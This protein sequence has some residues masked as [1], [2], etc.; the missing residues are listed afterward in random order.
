MTADV[1][2]DITVTTG[3]SHNC[4][5]IPTSVWSVTTVSGDIDDSGDWL[6]TGGDDRVRGGL[7]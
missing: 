5:H 2:A 6:C 4:N 7:H 1:M 3:L